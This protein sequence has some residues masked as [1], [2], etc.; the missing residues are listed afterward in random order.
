MMKESSNIEI[1]LI[2]Q[3]TCTQQMKKQINETTSVCWIYKNGLEI[4]SIT[5]L[6]DKIK[7]HLVTSEQVKL[8]ISII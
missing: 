4:F 1:F 7:L 2:E 6:Q 8:K 5:C 3:L